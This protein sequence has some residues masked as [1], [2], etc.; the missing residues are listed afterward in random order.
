MKNLIYIIGFVFITSTSTQ[1]ANECKKLIDKA[2]PS[3]W[4]LN[5]ITDKKKEI[6]E[7]NKTL[8][9]VYKNIKPK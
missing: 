4:A 5:K 7:K 2:K 6:D 8:F 9:D 3:C 1:A